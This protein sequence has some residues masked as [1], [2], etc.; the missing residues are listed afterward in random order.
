[1]QSCRFQSRAAAEAKAAAS[2]A[3]RDSLS[4]SAAAQGKSGSMRSR[5]RPPARLHQPRN[6]LFPFLPLHSRS[7]PLCAIPRSPSISLRLLIPFLP[8]RS[9]SII[10]CALPRSPSI[11]LRLLIPFPPLRSLV[12][13]PHSAAW[14]CARCTWT[15]TA[16]SRSSRNTA[17]TAPKVFGYCSRPASLAP[18]AL[19]SG[20]AV[21]AIA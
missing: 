2:H 20:A 18:V 13:A 10:L 1:M 11:F 12:P 21:Y 5:C 9:R 3:P 19:T 17:M 16:N 7:I 8:L 15:A 6:S 4:S 14:D